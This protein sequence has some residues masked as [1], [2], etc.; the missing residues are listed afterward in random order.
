M[1]MVT[2][3]EQDAARQWLAKRGQPVGQPTSL[4]TALIA[5]RQAISLRYLGYLLVAVVAAAGYSRLF[6]SG[7]TESAPVYFLYLAVQLSVRDTVRRRERNLHAE[8]RVEASAEP[9]RKVL[10]GWYLAS[11]V[12]AFA[13]GP[14]LAVTMY[15]TTSA[16]TY[17]LSWLGLL[18]LSAL[19]GAWV[20]VGVLRG[21]VFAETVESVAVDRALRS[22]KIYAATPVL[23]AFPLVLDLM[24]DNRQSAAFTPW[25][26]GYIAAVVVLQ[27]VSYA[28]HR[29]R[30]R[31]LPPG[32]YGTPLVPDPGTP[33]DWSPPQEAR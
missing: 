7:M 29:R 9:W 19:C 14:A 24:L 30:F 13:G 6:G 27:G 15:L 5:T 1:I 10:G 16:R 3:K 2:A 22:E 8:V 31:T 23:A 20:L 26:A 11:L 12:V 28:V 18:A 32:H 4:L 17:A 33:V 21:P 25:L